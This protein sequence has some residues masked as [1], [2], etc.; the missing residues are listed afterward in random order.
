MQNTVETPGIASHIARYLQ[1]NDI[2][3]LYVL[4]N[5][6]RVRHELYPFCKTMICDFYIKQKRIEVENILTK[7]IHH[8]LEHILK[9]V[10]HNEKLK[11]T[12][13]MFEYMCTEKEN[14]YILGKCFGRT[15]ERRLYEL[16]DILDENDEKEY[17]L[18]MKIEQELWDYFNWCYTVIF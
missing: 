4:F 2:K 10:T 14:M 15:V 12:I 1:S 17:L 7:N 8:Y 18:T 5:N 6:E 3:S 9:A 16:I 11:Y 13:K